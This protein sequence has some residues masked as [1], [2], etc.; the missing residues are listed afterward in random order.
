MLLE[1]LLRRNKRLGEQTDK[2]YMVRHFRKRFDSQTLTE[3]CYNNAQLLT[4]I[5]DTIDAHPDW[6]DETV[7]ENVEFN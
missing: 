7:A 6:D 3:I 1:E 2:V 4:S 5:L